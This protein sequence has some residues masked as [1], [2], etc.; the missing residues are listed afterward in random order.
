[1]T[2]ASARKQH[3]QHRGQA[4]ILTFD[5]AV[6]RSFPNRRIEGLPPNRFVVRAL[7]YG[8]INL[9]HYLYGSTESG[10]RE[11]GAVTLRSE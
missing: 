7:V 9:D 6:K 8:S 10:G 11:E 4:S 5:Q 3:R 1:M 2:K